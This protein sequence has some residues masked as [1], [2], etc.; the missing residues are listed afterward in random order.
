MSADVHDLISSVEAKARE[1]AEVVAALNAA[2]HEAHRF[3]SD[4]LAE[5]VELVVKCMPGVRAR[6]AEAN[7]P[8][9]PAVTLEFSKR[10]KAPE[11][12]EFVRRTATLAIIRRGS[13][14][15]RFRLKDGFRDGKSGSWYGHWRISAPDLDRIR[16]MPVG[17]NEVSRALKALEAAK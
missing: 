4:R 3:R 17:E 1:L 15:D 7:R 11:I 14:E 12:A 6:L 16:A 8:K 2:T 9:G 13:T 10:G 5:N